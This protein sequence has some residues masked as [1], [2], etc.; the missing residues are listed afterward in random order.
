VQDEKNGDET[1]QR[2]NERGI[3]RRGKGRDAGTARALWERED[4]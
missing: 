1:R 3:M 4:V 2:E